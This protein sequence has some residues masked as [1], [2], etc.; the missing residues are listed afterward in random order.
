[1]ER[2]QRIR[3]KSIWKKFL[4]LSAM[5]YVSVQNCG[6]CI[7]DSFILFHHNLFNL[8]LSEFNQAA[9]DDDSLN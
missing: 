2:S 3:C 1:M 9:S 6:T 5:S 7:P 8:I 4:G